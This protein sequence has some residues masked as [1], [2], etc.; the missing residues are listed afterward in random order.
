MFPRASSFALAASLACGVAYAQDSK[1]EAEKAKAEL[2]K[3]E[4]AIKAELAKPISTPLSSEAAPDKAATTGSRFVTRPGT[5]GAKSVRSAPSVTLPDGPL[6]KAPA[7][8]SRVIGD[9]QRAA[10]MPLDAYQKEINL[11]GLKK[12]DPAARPTVLHTRNGVNEI[13]RL[14]SRL[15]NRIATPFKDPRVVGDVPE[16]DS[17]QIV[18]SDVYLRPQGEQ[19]MGVFIVDGANTSQVISLTIIPTPEIPGQNL[20]VKLEDLRT[21]KPLAGGGSAEEQEINQPRSTDYV[22]N[23]RQIMAQAVRGKI[24]GF[25]AVPIEGGT[26]K[27]GAIEV[28]PEYAFTGST[29]DV[30]R[31]SIK[32]ASEEVVDLAETAF[33]RKGV[34]AVSF[35]PSISLPPGEAGY[36]FLLADKPKS[37]QAQSEVFE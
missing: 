3:T 6:G 15:P 8:I 12:D 27:M 14:S 11:P 9:A 19:P 5:G 26:A 34:K 18:G 25:A 37:A 4:A 22:G 10:G 29:V 30:Y 31:Y 33:Y 24:R 21:V 7:D 36:V 13:V 1:S 16:D 20:I 23:V 17:Q 28:T 2:Q 35:F 32:N